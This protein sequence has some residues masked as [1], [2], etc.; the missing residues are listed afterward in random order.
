MQLLPT[1]SNSSKIK[2]ADD[3]VYQ[4][5]TSPLCGVQIVC[6]DCIH[7]AYIKGPSDIIKN[8]DLAARSTVHVLQ[9]M[10]YGRSIQMS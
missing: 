8:F 5:N 1:A 2:T 6:R 3:K 7:L 9:N 10:V 4:S